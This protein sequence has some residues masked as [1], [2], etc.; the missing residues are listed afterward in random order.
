MKEMF[1][2]VKLIE[3]KCIGCNQCM[4]NCPVQAVRL[5][6]SK[7]IIYNDR[8]ID[9]GEC[10]KVCPH[11]AHIAEKNE[12]DVIDGFKIKVALPSVTIYTQFGNYVN[13]ALVDEGIQSLGFDEVFDMSYAC[14]VVAEICK[15]EIKNTPKP[16]ISNFCPTVV[17][18]IQSNFPDLLEHIV[19]VMDPIEVAAGLVRE[20]Y[21]AMGYKNDEIGVFYL[22]SCV[23]W[24]TRAKYTSLNPNFEINAS[25]AISDIYTPILKYIQKNAD[26]SLGNTSELSYSGLSWATIGG[27]GEYMGAPEY[28]SVDGVV[29]V[30]RVL[31]DIEKGKFHDL[32][33]IEAMACAEGCVGGLFSVDNPYNARRVMKKFKDKIKK[34]H[35]LN[36]LK[37]NKK[38]EFKI[39]TNVNMSTNQKLGD[40]FL[41]ALKKMKH[42]NNLIN[43]LP[44]YDCSQC[45][46]PS[47]K[48]FAEDVVRGLSTIEGCKFIK[49]DITK[50]E[51]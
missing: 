26:R 50:Y 38:Q 41:S 18:L 2:S 32:D 25:I 5:K 37:D 1:H 40:D 49:E 47:C 51:D 34:K 42:M 36:K 9:C 3:E 23:T 15:K 7:A 29:N 16:A 20:K 13:P 46:S 31:E 12:I 33:Y 48:A 4:I 11:N 35:V 44:G 30:I 19:K 39:N 45:G 27:E 17:R 43:L 14:D 24:I 8:C 10:I 6:D 22:S 28:I 21:T